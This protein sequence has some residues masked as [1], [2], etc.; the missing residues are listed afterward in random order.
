MPGEELEDGLLAAQKLHALGIG[1]ILTNLGENVTREEDAEEV[2]RHYVGALDRI[3][4]SGINAH[5]SVKLTQLGLDMG[6]ELCYEKLARLVQCADRHGNVVWIDMESSP[7][8]DRT[9]ALFKRARSESRNVGLC[10]Q[11]YLYRTASDLAGL[12]PLGPTI[13]LVKGAYNEPR[14]VAFADKASV[15]ANFFAL[16]V[17]LLDGEPRRQGAFGA[18]ATHD[19]RLIDR[20]RRHAREHDVSPKTYEFDMLYGIKGALQRGLRD[21]GEQV[22]I[23]VSYGAYWF[24]W[25]MRRLAERP[26]NVLFVA[27]NLIGA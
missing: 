22:R 2:T 12:L 26:A 9:I 4:A 23:L 17:R 19:G 10:L 18:F 11:A 21:E 24:P 6:A 16:A 7:Y 5:I 3:A 8:V 14:H 15:D 25:Y 1:S 27:R 13:R 20:I